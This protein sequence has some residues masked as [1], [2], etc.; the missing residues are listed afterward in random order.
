ILGLVHPDSG[1]IRLFGKDLRELQDV[2]RAKLGAALAETGLSGELT[3][4][5]TVRVLRAFYSAFDEPFFRRKC[6]ELGLPRDKQIKNFSTGMKAKLKVLVAVSHKAQLLILDEPTAGLDVLARDQTLS[7]LREYMEQDDQRAILIS[8][9]I[10]NDLESICDDFYMLNDGRIVFHEDT[11]KL[12]SDY[13]IIKLDEEQ[14]SALD[15]RYILRRLKEN[16]GYRLLTD[17]RRYYRENYPNL[18]VERA[19]MDEFIM[20]ML[21][22]EAL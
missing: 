18:V 16:Y 15:Q 6:D 7:L 8:S 9:H 5:D 21:K 13:A 11:D 1:S 3:V 22:G 14:L 10:S 19:S 4:E 12:M 2:D 17:Q 20:L